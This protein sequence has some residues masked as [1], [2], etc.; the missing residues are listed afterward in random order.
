M[1]NILTNPN[2]APTR[3]DLAVHSDGSL[4]LASYV[5]EILPNPDAVLSSLGGNVKEYGKLR[6][7]DQ[8]AALMPRQV[9]PAFAEAVAAG[10][11]K[12]V[13]ASFYQPNSPH[14][15]VPGVYYLRHV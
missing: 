12:K 4:D 6:R 5:A 7:D 15:P 13:S 14:N 11:Y 9:D 10:R 1:A 2:A 3:A 8:V